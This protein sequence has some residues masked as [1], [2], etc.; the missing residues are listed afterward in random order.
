MKKFGLFFLLFGLTL[1][2]SAAA[3][4]VDVKISGEY[5]A[6]GMYLDRTTLKKD[7]ASEG[8]ST[9]FFFQRLR[10]L[11]D[12]TISPGL[13]L[14]TRFD[15]LERSWG[16][17]RSAATS[18]TYNSATG[19]VTTSSASYDTAS[20]GTRAENENIALD[21]AYIHYVSPVGLFRVG[22]M[23]DNIWGTVFADGATP[24]GKIMWSYTQGSWLVTLGIVKMFYDKSYSVVN[25][26]TTASDVDNDK[27]VAAVKYTWKNGETG[28]LGAVGRDSTTRPANN[29]KALFYALMPYASAQVG[30]VKLQAELNY[31][32]G[33]WQIYETSQTDLDMTALLA[34]VD[35]TADFGK[36]YVGG[37]IAYV[38][39]DDPGSTDKIEA[40]SLLVNGGRDWN[41]CL[42]LFNSDLT[43]WA[44]NQVGHNPSSGPAPT[45]V[46]PN[47]Y[48]FSNGPMANAW[49]IQGRAG[50]KPVDKLDIMAS[51]AFASADKKPTADWL[52]NDYGYEVDVTASYK[53]TNNLSYMLGAGYLFTGKYFKGTAENQNVRDNY[54]LINKLTLTF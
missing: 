24:K 32:W 11:T 10:V 54:L 35:A 13:K 20:S 45:P 53:I 26:T 25:N 16:A 30:P 21:W 33:K 2:F 29:Y 43:Y 39:G 38:S 28:L 12:F 36:F 50:V 44:G 8:P 17:T 37:S 40:N 34:W 14:I 1:V 19:G 52:Y 23:N 46:A 48:G 41:P 5:Y 3:G 22:F 31:F 27:Y 51:V 18:S 49:F 6:A 42:I 47:P 7:V 15:A 4:A 9:A